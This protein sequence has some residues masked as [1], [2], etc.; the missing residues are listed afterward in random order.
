MTARGKLQV[1]DVSGRTNIA[2]AGI[3]M[4]QRVDGLR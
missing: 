4:A 1:T 2:G 3:N